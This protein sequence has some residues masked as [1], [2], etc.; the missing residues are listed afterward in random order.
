MVNPRASLERSIGD[1]EG[2]V[3]AMGS[4]V[5]RAIDRAIDALRRLDREAA[6]SIIADDMAINQRRFDIENKAIRIIATQQPTA[7]DLR[8]I[9]AVINIIVD[10]ERMGDHAA[11]IA[12]IVRL[13]PSSEGLLKPLIDVPRMA[14]KGRDM[15]RR[16]LDAFVSRDAEAARQ[17]ATE[18]DEVDDLQDQVYNE[19]I[20][21]MIQDPRTVPRATYLIWVSHNLERI[22]DLVT[23]VC[24]RIVFEATGHMEEMNVSR[25]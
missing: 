19:L 24:E 17:I 16:A 3:V 9:I 23:N 2:D 21:F 18:D 15:L 12:K 10:M 11:G 7:S 8:R 25:L 22:A 6:A 13:H 1:L 5:D 14:E 4:M 20:F